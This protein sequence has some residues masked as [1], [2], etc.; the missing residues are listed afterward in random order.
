ML[1][2][3]TCINCIQNWAYYFMLL[4]KLIAEYVSRKISVMWHIIWQ[5]FFYFQCPGKKSTE[6]HEIYTMTVNNTKDRSHC[7]KSNLASQYLDSSEE[8][9]RYP[10]WSWGSLYSSSPESQS[11]QVESVKI[12]KHFKWAG[13]Q[14]YP[15][16]KRK[17]LASWSIRNKRWSQIPP[18]F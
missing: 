11:G 7:L 13:R 5:I 17:V 6:N 8:H 14:S 1:F 3:L 12:S 15:V 18:N 16:A 4:N 2:L 9:R 10:Q